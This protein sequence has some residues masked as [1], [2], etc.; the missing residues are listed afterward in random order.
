VILDSGSTISLFKSKNLVTE[1]KDTKEKIQLETNA[2]TRVVDRE[3]Q[4]K[5]FDKVYL[6]ESGRH[7]VTYDSNK[8]DA[9]VVHIENKPITFRVNQKGLYVF[10]FPENY[11]NYVEMKNTSN[12]GL[13]LQPNATK[14]EGYC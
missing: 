10:N 11:M 3:V 2:G 13:C 7:R 5:G 4:I 9:F 6:N 8:E 1:I 14:I 12:A